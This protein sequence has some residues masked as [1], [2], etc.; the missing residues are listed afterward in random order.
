V[1]FPNPRSITRTTSDSLSSTMSTS[2]TAI[3]IHQ[4]AMTASKIELVQLMHVSPCHA[5][6]VGQL[7]TQG[8][9]R[10]ARW[11]RVAQRGLDKRK[12][13]PNTTPPGPCIFLHMPPILL[14]ILLTY[15][16]RWEESEVLYTSSEKAMLASRI[17]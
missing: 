4:R 14:I 15:L 8:D 16:C 12:N 2:V 5:G 10:Y 13:S 7:G 6:R 3:A 17:L 1:H 11:A 9:S